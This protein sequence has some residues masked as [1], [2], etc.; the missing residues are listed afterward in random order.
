MS[1]VPIPVLEGFIETTLC[2]YGI[3]LLRY[4]TKPTTWSKP[5]T[6]NGP[7]LRQVAGA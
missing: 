3:V 5:Q 4:D 7:A 2:I 1:T 6:V